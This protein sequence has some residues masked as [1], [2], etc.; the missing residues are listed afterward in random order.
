MERHFISLSTEIKSDWVLR[1]RLPLQLSRA[2]TST[3]SVPNVAFLNFNS[4]ENETNVRKGRVK[5]TVFTVRCDLTAL[6]RLNNSKSHL[7][8]YIC[9]W[10]RWRRGWWTELEEEKKQVNCISMYGFS[11]TTHHHLR[12]CVMTSIF[13]LRRISNRVRQSDCDVSF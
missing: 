1:L 8:F 13:Q 6:E 11:L 7:F 12:N 5:L 2:P 10:W 9:P 4:E 3:C